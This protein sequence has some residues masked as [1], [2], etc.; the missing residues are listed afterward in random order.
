MKECH[1]FI[2]SGEYLLQ[3]PKFNALMMRIVDNRDELHAEEWEEEL[4]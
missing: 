3:R 4:G 2:K 1:D